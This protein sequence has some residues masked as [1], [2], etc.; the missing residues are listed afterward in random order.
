MMVVPITATLT[1]DILLATKY[2]KSNKNKKNN[3]EKKTLAL[4]CMQANNI[5]CSKSGSELGTEV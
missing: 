5:P 2:Y 3:D 1:F 4:T